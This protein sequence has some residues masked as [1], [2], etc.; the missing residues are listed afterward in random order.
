MT[1]WAEA[2]HGKK[3]TPAKFGG[4]RHRGSGHIVLAFQ[5]VSQYHAIGIVVTE[6]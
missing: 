6:K 2:T 3:Q 4:N 1:L 5:M